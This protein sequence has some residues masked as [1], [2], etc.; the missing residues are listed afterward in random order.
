MPQSS[1]NFAP[2]MYNEYP[3]ESQHAMTLNEYGGVPIAHGLTP[4]PYSAQPV[5]RTFYGEEPRLVHPYQ[6]D[7]MR[8][9]SSANLSHQYNS[10]TPS[11]PLLTTTYRPSP[12]AEN[13]LDRHSEPL[14]SSTTPIISG[15]PGIPYES[16]DDIRHLREDVS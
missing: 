14:S 4:R 2:S 1:S 8:R 13:I 9:H 5:P 3:I 16:D 6:S 12:H 11:P 10:G 7:G 15:L